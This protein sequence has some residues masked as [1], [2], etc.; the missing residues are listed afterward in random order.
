VCDEECCSLIGSTTLWQ[1]HYQTVRCLHNCDKIWPWCNI[2][3][4]SVSDRNPGQ[5][6]AQTS[7]HSIM[8][9]LYNS[10]LLFFKSVFYTST[11]AHTRRTR[12]SPGLLWQTLC[13]PELSIILSPHNFQMD[14]PLHLGC[15]ECL[16]CTYHPYGMS[17]PLLLKGD[18]EPTTYTWDEPTPLQS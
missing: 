13:I 1:W 10:P 15:V 17:T 12:T 14:L 7:P 6:T 4:C 3:V 18:Q 5:F 2:T 11:G 9:I 8:I 16:L